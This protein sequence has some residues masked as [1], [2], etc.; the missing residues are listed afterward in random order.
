MVHRRRTQ[1]TMNIFGKHTHD[2]HLSPTHT[3]QDL[4]RDLFV[5]PASKPSSSSTAGPPRRRRG[6]SSATAIL[7][8]PSLPASS[9]QYDPASISTAGTNR[10]SRRVSGTPSS[11][12]SH[13]PGD[14]PTSTTHNHPIPHPSRYRQSRGHNAAPSSIYPTIR[15]GS[16][17]YAPSS[18]SDSMFP[19][20]ASSPLDSTGG[21][22]L[23]QVVLVSG[24]EEAS[25]AVQMKVGEVMRTKRVVVLPEPGDR[26]EE[27][28][29][30][31]KRQE[32]ED[33]A[34]AE[35]GE[36]EGERGTPVG[37]WNLPRGFIIIWVKVVS[38]QGEE[39]EEVGGVGVGGEKTVGSWLVSRSRINLS[40][41]LH[42]RLLTLFSI[43]HVPML[44]YDLFTL[45][46]DVPPLHPDIEAMIPP[47][48]L[49]PLITPDVRHVSAILSCSQQI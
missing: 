42:A 23:P 3:P 6:S 10:T 14:S 31:K 35:A 37:S 13:Y 26:E 21:A 19:A 32:E 11:R 45:T 28:K 47:P 38:A 20:S 25:H 40:I 30:E 12:H 46:Y 34:A 16:H 49:H 7:Q 4:L 15:P 8:P 1:V 18:A 9:S 39:R 2:V 5:H 17:L 27:K 48:S 24:L 43:V 33:E 44:Q 29:M 22:Y 36:Q 41:S